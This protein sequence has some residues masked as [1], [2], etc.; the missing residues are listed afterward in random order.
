[1]LHSIHNNWLSRSVENGACCSC[2]WI[3]TAG[4]KYRHQVFLLFAV[5]IH[6]FQHKKYLLRKDK[7]PI[8]Q[9]AA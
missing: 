7:I 6:G 3:L 8:A 2:G 1:M 9:P 5:F 4:S